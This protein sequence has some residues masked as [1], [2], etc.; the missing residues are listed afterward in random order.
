MIDDAF[1]QSIATGLPVYLDHQR[2]YADKLRPIRSLD[3]VDLAIVERGA[4]QVHI[5]LIGIDYDV[6]DSRRYF[7]PMTVHA[8]PT[9][10]RY[11]I[12]V[13]AGEGGRRWVQDAPSDAVFR[14]FFTKPAKG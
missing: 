7:V 11:T 13:A 14:D 3:L 6:G 9:P 1:W 4:S 12:A 8:E 10:E 5:A 2:W